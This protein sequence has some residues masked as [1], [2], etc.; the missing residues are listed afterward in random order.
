MQN[1]N[2]SAIKPSIL[3][4]ICHSPTNYVT[5]IISGPVVSNGSFY[6]SEYKW[7]SS[8]WVDIWVRPSLVLISSDANQSWFTFSVLFV[9]TQHF[10]PC[11]FHLQCVWPQHDHCVYPVFI[12]HVDWIKKKNSL[13]LN[14]TCVLHTSCL[15]LLDYK[16]FQLEGLG[17]PFGMQLMTNHHNNS[18]KLL[19]KKN[20]TKIVCVLNIS[21]LLCSGNFLSQHS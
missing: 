21:M 1:P 18:E 14:E 8:H 6:E 13:N 16:Y 7:E 4:L 2:S 19:W 10:P 11:V 3:K 9:Y 17:F 12:W 15:A 5:W 20:L